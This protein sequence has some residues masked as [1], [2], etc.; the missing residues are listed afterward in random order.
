MTQEAADLIAP[1]PQAHICRALVEGR[2]AKQALIDE[3]DPDYGG[4][5]V[6][7]GNIGV[8]PDL[9]PED[10]DWA[11]SRP[12]PS[13]PWRVGPMLGQHYFG[14]DWKPRLIRR[15]ELRRADVEDAFGIAEQPAPEQPAPQQRA[16]TP[17]AKAAPAPRRSGPRPVKREKVKAKMLDHIRDEEFTFEELRD[18]KWEALAK[19]YGASIKVCR[20]ALKEIDNTR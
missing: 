6:S 2:I 9:R 13:K 17:A 3:S 4:R 14:P 15:L 7:D 20:A 5:L 8:P 11:N 12:L 10:I 1:Q 16:P 19:L 18:M